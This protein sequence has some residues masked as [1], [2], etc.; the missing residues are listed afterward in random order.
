M[1]K[2]VRNRTSKKARKLQNVKKQRERELK[3]QNPNGI[4]SKAMGSPKDT[5]KEQT[6]LP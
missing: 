4:L 3:E 1:K 2:K 6:N 5:T